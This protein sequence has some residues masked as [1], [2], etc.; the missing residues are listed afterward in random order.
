MEAQAPK[1][2]PIPST[3]PRTDGLA[4]ELWRSGQGADYD[5]A[6]LGGVHCFASTRRTIGSNVSIGS[7]G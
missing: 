5:V 2:A 4:A 1:T 3:I 7:F 6:E